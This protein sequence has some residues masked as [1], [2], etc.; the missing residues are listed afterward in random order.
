MAA[1]PPSMPPAG[2]A[3]P[4]RPE[5][6][7][8]RQE[9][10]EGQGLLQVAPP[11]TWLLLLW[12]L[13]GL[14][15]AL[16]AAIFGQVEI[17]GR[18][19]GILRPAAGIRLVLAQVDGTISQVERHSGDPVR[20]GDPLA[21]IEAPPVRAQLVEARRQLEAVHD[22]FRMAAARQD[23]AQ[24]EQARRLE[25][26]AGRLALQIASQRRSLDR[27]AHDLDRH[28]ALEREGILSPAAAD[29]ARESLATVERQLSGAEQALDQVDQE[30]AAL[31]AQRADRLWQHRQTI[32]NAEARVEAL[33]VLHGQTL[34]AA[35]EDGRVEAML[36]KPGESVRAGQA[37]CKLIPGHAQLHVVTFLPEKDR[38]FVRPGDLVHL[39]LDQLPY[40]EYGTLRARIERISDDLASPF[41][42]QEALGEHPPPEAATFRV[43]LGL[44][45]DA[46]AARAGVPLRSGMLLQA[47]FTL[48]R[49][50]LIT[51]VLGPLR[52]WLR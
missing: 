29:Q 17:N 23:R 51:L 13:S 39:E 18:G 47:R 32:Q 3:S 10:E 9:A 30:R 38:A 33:T 8:H 19:R 42:I 2:P 34:L 4:F 7:R 21:R 31:T 48:R 27:G 11:W 5:A 40:A 6:L 50:R 25:A 44:L 22:H 35:P 49:Q 41:E 52:K 43:E 15:S 12:L 24:A 36:V 1:G 45:D 20:A 37:I 28:L 16:A 46:P 26:R 14:A